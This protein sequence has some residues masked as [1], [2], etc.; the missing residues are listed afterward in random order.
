MKN[1]FNKKFYMSIVCL[2][3]V[4]IIPLCSINLYNYSS[5][6]AATSQEETIDDDNSAP[7]DDGNQENAD[8]DSNLENGTDDADNSADTGEE[9]GETA[10]NN[11]EETSAT[12]SG[13]W[14]DYAEKPIR[15]SDYAYRISSASNLAWMATLSGG[16]TELIATYNLTANIDL[17]AHYWVPIQNFY[18]VFNGNG[19]TISGLTIDI[20]RLYADGKVSNKNESSFGLFAQIDYEAYYGEVEVA[21]ND[22]IIEDL[23]VNGYITGNYNQNIRDVGGLVGTIFWRDYALTPVRITDV[24]CN[25]D[26]VVNYDV[27]DN[28]TNANAVGGFVG[29]VRAFTSFSSGGNDREIHLTRCINIG[30]I[31]AMLGYSSVG[32]I[33]GFAQNHV[34]ITDCIN[35]GDI[36]HG[37]GQWTGGIVGY[38]QGSN[39]NPKEHDRNIVS[40]SQCVNY[41]VVSG[42]HYY[43]YDTYTGGIVG[44]L[45]F[46]SGRSYYGSIV[47]D[48]INFSGVHANHNDIGGSGTA[49]LG[50]IIGYVVGHVEKCQSIRFNSTYTNQKPFGHI[51][52]SETV[53]SASTDS[54]KHGVYFEN[55]AIKGD[56][57]Y[58]GDDESDSTWTSI[59]HKWTNRWQSSYIYDNY[60]YSDSI[61]ALSDYAANHNSDDNYTISIKQGVYLLTLTNYVRVMEIDIKVENSDGTLSDYYGDDFYIGYSAHGIYGVQAGL[62]EISLG[63]YR[64]CSTVTQNEITAFTINNNTDDYGFSVWETL[65]NGELGNNILSTCSR[66][67]DYWLS[68]GTY[69]S[70]FVDITIVLEPREL[71]EEIYG[72]FGV[73]EVFSEDFYQGQDYFSDLTLLRGSSGGEATITV[74]G[75][76]V[77]DYTELDADSQVTIYLRPRAGYEILGLYSAKYYDDGNGQVNMRLDRAYNSYGGNTVSVNAR[78]FMLH[79]SASYSFRIGDMIDELNSDVSSNSI[80]CGDTNPV[81]Y[82]YTFYAVFVKSI[83]T[84]YLD[85][86]YD[87][88]AQ[89]GSGRQRLIYG[90]YEPTYMVK[91]GYYEFAVRDDYTL[92]FFE[93]GDTSRVPTN[94]LELSYGSDYFE[95]P[96]PGN[97]QYVAEFS[98]GKSGYWSTVGLANNAEGLT[99]AEK[100]VELN[101]IE[102]LIDAGVEPGSTTVITFHRF[103]GPK[104]TYHY[105]LQIADAYED[106]ETGE[107]EL[108]TLVGEIYLY[109]RSLISKTNATFGDVT[110]PVSRIPFNATFTTYFMFDTS[111]PLES[112][113]SDIIDFKNIIEYSTQTVG[114]GQVSIASTLNQVVSR[115]EKNPIVGYR[116]LT[117]NYY[118]YD[119]TLGEAGEQYYGTTTLLDLM[120]RYGDFSQE[121]YTI[122]LYSLFH[123]RNPYTV[124]IRTAVNGTARTFSMPELSDEY[125][126]TAEGRN[127]SGYSVSLS[128]DPFEMIDI[129]VTDKLVYYYNQ[130]TRQTTFYSFDNI[131]IGNSV[132]S[133]SGEYSFQM[134][135]TNN[136]SSVVISINFKEEFT[137]NNNILN[138]DNSINYSASIWEVDSSTDL[139]NI[140]YRMYCQGLPLAKKIVQTADIDFEGGYMLPIGTESNPFES[141]YD[142]GYYRI[143]NMN[144]AG[145]NAVDMGLFGYT[146]GATIKNLT[147]MNSSVSGRGNVGAVI[148]YGNDTTL[149]RVGVYDGTTTL[150]EEQASGT[151]I[152]LT[153][154]TSVANINKASGTYTNSALGNNST[155][156]TIL[157]VMIE[158]AVEN[159]SDEAGYAGDLAGNLNNSTIDTCYERKSNTENSEIGGL[160]GRATSGSITY[161][162]TSRARVVYSSSGVSQSHAHTGVTNISSTCGACAD[163]FIW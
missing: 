69:S 2:L 10:D 90:Y 95:S 88:D 103:E 18:G 102:F 117:S 1:I 143:E 66:S 38:A 135:P 74:N 125:I 122:T 46:V 75:Q 54:E 81:T 45:G 20:N 155:R 120:E 133:E 119:Y 109:N 7:T 11:N 152:F 89:Y 144:I 34:S 150:V 104:Y 154:G 49:Y 84:Y 163:R 55:T 31:R 161:S 160:V 57:E 82:A 132:L 79:Y 98:E 70:D 127:V 139:L 22:V 87:K 151:G 158:D 73:V 19:Y 137:I 110:A 142:G 93:L 33:V 36:S 16:A 101:L 116:G 157:N 25:I 44:Q 67:E 162:Y 27:L 118:A 24:V 124:T 146:D 86:R 76:T 39:L 153:N 130:T 21:S 72:G 145:G 61:G 28:T 6:L 85:V 100:I 80:D 78:S 77:S 48:C 140:A 42:C 3:L 4:A 121:G 43:N 113:Y 8:G 131:S 94:V 136:T 32:G 26:I 148:G 105:Y 147:L 112:Y 13:Y 5:L 63:N 15:G 29:S 30:N 129:S 35:Y 111:S 14:T 40:V 123:V 99:L 71:K 53:D 64:F 126:F 134:I 138:S 56:F 62:T 59:E 65:E 128:C 37:Y 12:A 60:I 96:M 92:N 51:A 47:S 50:N 83:E 91:D 156:Y 114:G 52:N 68:A 141:V 149:E 108:G 9:Q 17:S 159:S 41:G 97:V 23:I 106:Y 58:I 107:Y 115:V